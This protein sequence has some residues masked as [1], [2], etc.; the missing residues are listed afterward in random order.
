MKLWEAG[1]ARLRIEHTRSPFPLR[2]RGNSSCDVPAS[3]MES[4]QGHQ[5]SQGSPEN[6]ETRTQDEPNRLQTDGHVKHREHGVR[7]EA[8][9]DELGSRL[10]DEIASVAGHADAEQKSSH[11]WAFQNND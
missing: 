11:N 7:L 6:L 10:R 4:L 9:S 8:A 5:P 2:L 1:K 3:V